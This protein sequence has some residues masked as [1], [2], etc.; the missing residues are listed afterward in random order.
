MRH[1]PPLLVLGL[2]AA[3]DPS[4]RVVAPPD[5]YADVG[6]PGAT[7]DNEPVDP[8]FDTAPNEV[9]PVDVAVV[10][11]GLDY[12]CAIQDDDGAVACWGNTADGRLDVP[13]GAAFRS[14]DVGDDVACGVL[15]DGTL[16]CW[17]PRA[18]DLGTLPDGESFDAVVMGPVGGCAIDLAGLAT[19]FGPVDQPPE[20]LGPVSRIGLASDAV[21]ALASSSAAVVCWE[22][23]Q[24]PDDGTPSTGIADDVPT[25]VFRDLAVGTNHACALELDGEPTC[26]GLSGGGQTEV[27]DDITELRRIFAGNRLTCGINDAGRPECWGASFAGQ[28]DAPEGFQYVFLAPGPQ[29]ACGVR[30]SG[31]VDCWGD[32]SSFQSTTPIRDAVAVEAGE[33]GFLCVTRADGRITCHGDDTG[34]RTSVPAGTGD[35]YALSVGYDHACA[36]DDMGTAG[37]PSDDR[38]VCWG[39]DTYGQVAPPADALGVPAASTAPVPLSTSARSSCVLRA[40]ASRAYCWGNGRDPF[41]ALVGSWTR[42]DGGD[43]HTC[44]VGADEGLECFGAGGDGQRDVPPGERWQGVSAGQ[45]V[46]CGLTV[47]GRIECFG[48]DTE[49]ETTGPGGNDWVALDLGEDH[50]CAIDEDGALGCWGLDDVDQA[51][52]PDGSYRDVTVGD[53]FSCAVEGASDDAGGGRLRCWGR[54]GL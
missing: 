17:G 11:V 13:A 27:P 43:F 8:V 30:V 7:L 48:L 18:D 54:V 47:S 28:S 10:G 14:V 49:G 16:T 39:D 32:D 52:P 19:C 1:L 24:A 45:K 5:P 41:E 42:L 25:G 31:A 44:A 46:T 34:G 29:H 15:T 53:G 40:D 23:T 21:C 33:S 51:S 50:G 2:V 37:D 26:W 6:E 20:T 4:A 36:L 38:P 12:T 9:I 35:L 3:C 22:N